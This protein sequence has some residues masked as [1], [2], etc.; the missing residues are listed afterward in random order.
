MPNAKAQTTPIRRS[1][2]SVLPV[3]AHAP[4]IQ[5]AG[6]S[7]D[8]TREYDYSVQIGYL[9]RRAYQSHM[10]I[11][12][13]FNVDPQLTSVQFAA[14][15]AL[16]DNGASSLTMLGRATGTDFATIRGVVD[17]LSE[18]KFV[19]LCGD[20]RDQRKVIV[21]LSRSGSSLVRRMIP[22]AYK[23]NDLT[24][25][26]LNPAERLALVYLLTKMAKA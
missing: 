18:R 19:S 20:S 23:I 1:K 24:A 4:Q 16:R 8:R 7:K 9:L 2:T 22:Q 5:A 14:L 10:A 13:R 11:F 25:R 21:R 12:Q 6:S 17:R 26:S 3:S 15:C